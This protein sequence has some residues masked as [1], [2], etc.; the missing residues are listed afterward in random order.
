MFAFCP[1]FVT[2]IVSVMVPYVCPVFSMWFEYPDLLLLFLMVSMCSLN[3]ILNVLPVCPMY[4]SGQ[5][6]HLI[7]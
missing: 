7:W 4:F 2:P 3:L 6:R 1:L 5:S